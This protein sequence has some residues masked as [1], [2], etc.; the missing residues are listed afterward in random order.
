MPRYEEF[1]DLLI[2]GDSAA[3]DT[4]LATKADQDGGGTAALTNYSNVT[5]SQL[6]SA[7][8][9][10][11]GD[12]VERHIWVIAAGAADPAGAGPDDLIFEEQP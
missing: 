11:D 3:T 4:D 9:I 7:G 2:G 6:N 10:T 1:D 8:P 12:G 5:T